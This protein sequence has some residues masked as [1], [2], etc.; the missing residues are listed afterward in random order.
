VHSPAQKGRHSFLRLPSGSERIISA[1]CSSSQ[2]HVLQSQTIASKSSDIWLRMLVLTGR[3]LYAAG[4][5]GCAP[6]K[7]AGF[8]RFFRRFGS[9]QVI[10]HNRPCASNA[11][12]AV[13]LLIRLSYM[14]TPPCE[15]RHKTA[16]HLWPR[17]S[18]TSS[19]QMCWHC[20]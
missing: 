2:T 17:A 6:K 5:A 16:H 11:S 8:P 3:P 20:R 9:V 12:C 19:L 18:L 10:H 14:L 4:C 13:T 7:C 1:A 15:A